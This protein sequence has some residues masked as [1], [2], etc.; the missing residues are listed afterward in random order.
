MYL[1]LLSLALLAGTLNAAD[2]ASPTTLPAGKVACFTVKQLRDY[3]SY[4]DVAPAFAEDMLARATC[5]IN[6]EEQP[7]VLDGS[8]EGYTRYK[9]LSGHKVWVANDQ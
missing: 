9:L 3:Q 2:T 4:T 7:A 8:M 6:K 5:F 1:R